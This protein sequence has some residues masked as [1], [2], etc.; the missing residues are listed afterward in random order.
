LPSGA[1]PLGP[2]GPPA[3]AGPLGSAWPELLGAV[4]RAG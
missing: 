1:E 3:S 2:A 4:M